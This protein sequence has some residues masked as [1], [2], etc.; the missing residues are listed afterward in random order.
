MRMDPVSPLRGPCFYGLRFVVPLDI[1]GHKGVLRPRDREASTSV[2]RPASEM[3]QRHGLGLVCRYE[4]V[5][6][7]AT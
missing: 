6:G 7:H 1:G 3:A 4:Q 5:R 2:T